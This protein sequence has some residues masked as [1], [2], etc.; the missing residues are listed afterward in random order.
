MQFGIPI[1]MHVLFVKVFSRPPIAQNAVP[2]G[3]SVSLVVAEELLV[4]GDGC[5]TALGDEGEGLGLKGAALEGGGPLW[6]VLSAF[7]V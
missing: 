7:A 6:G 4:G 5:A 3:Q 2:G 1:P